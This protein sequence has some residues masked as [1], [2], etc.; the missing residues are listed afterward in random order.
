MKTRYYLCLVC[1]II[2]CAL[3]AILSIIAEYKYPNSAEKIETDP[4]K[5]VCD[6]DGNLTDIQLKDRALKC[7]LKK[8]HES[9]NFSKEKIAKKIDDIR[10]KYK[11]LHIEEDI[12][13]LELKDYL[14]RIHS[15]C[16]GDKRPDDKCEFYKIDKRLNLDYL[17]DL[18]SKIC[19]NGKAI[20]D[21]ETHIDKEIFK[22][23]VVYPWEDKESLILENGD[24]RYNLYFA[25]ESDMNKAIINYGVYK[26]K[27]DLQDPN[28]DINN[29]EASLIIPINL[30]F[31]NLYKPL[32]GEE[33]GNFKNNLEEFCMI[34]KIYENSDIDTSRPFNKIDFKY[35]DNYATYD[36]YIILIDKSFKYILG[37]RNML[38]SYMGYYYDE[39]EKTIKQISNNER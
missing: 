2:I 18:G 19:R 27:I 36:F 7:M 20:Q 11:N 4:Y 17:M 21:A 22:T 31:L 30:L 10:M 3:C 1:I 39:K 24:L 15:K 8:M 12:E 9:E 28:I 23:E 25:S 5:W 29:I 13:D 16:H 34:Y 33:N 35:R 14:T 37:Y 38:L 6:L 32:N 26:Y